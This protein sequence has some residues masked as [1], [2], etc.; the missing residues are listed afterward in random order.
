[1][2][3]AHGGRGKGDTVLRC[4]ALIVCCAADS[5]ADMSPAA[6]PQ[7][8]W[9]A[10]PLPP[11]RGGPGAPQRHSHTLTHVPAAGMVV[12]FGGVDGGGAVCN[13]V[14]CLRLP[15]AALAISRAPAERRPSKRDAAAAAR[16]DWSWEALRGQ[17]T[18]RAPPPRCGH[19]AA[20][21]GGLHGSSG[22]S[23]A[24]LGGRGRDDRQLGL[25]TLFVLALESWASGR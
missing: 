3:L 24:V 19:A 7:E 20:A 4:A 18:G 23:L 14:H 2:A 16:A 6:I 13:D 11:R 21:V 12:A 8:E 5:V 17:T 25:G 9:L 10:L 1:M 22:A 15:E